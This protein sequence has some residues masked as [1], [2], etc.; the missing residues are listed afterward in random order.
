MSRRDL[1]VFSLEAWDDVWRRNQYLIDG[2]LRRD[3]DLRVLFVEP[4]NDLLHSALSGRGIRRGRGLRTTSGYD[5]RLSLFQPDKV[6]PRVAGPAADAALRRAARR[7]M[8]SLGVTRPVLWVN[9]PGWAAL[10]AR[11][12]LPSVYDMTDDWLA[13]DRPARERHRIVANE[14]I[15]M[16]RCAAVVVCSTGLERSRSPERDVI[17]IPNAVDTAR[18]RAPLP[19]PADLPA[20]P[21]AVYVGT[22]HEDR[23][24]VDLVVR[25]AETIAAD[26]G[27]IVLVGP[28]ALATRNTELLTSHPDVAVL[29][30]RPF[31]D[32]PAYLQHA[33]S[34]IVPHVVDAFTDSLDPIKLYEYRAVGRPIV[35]TPVAG[36]R[37][38]E[39]EGIL[40]AARADFPLAV[41]AALRENAPTLTVADVPD[42][43]DRVDDYARVLEPLFA[44]AAAS[45]S[46]SSRPR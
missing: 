40:L 3:P 23:L 4:S 28:D 31:R 20:G 37:D 19:R 42:W 7:A 5:G 41:A 21:T 1:V 22:L 33:T 13:A 36:F 44:D 8:R 17:L 18:Y 35:S 14:A 34:L 45:A 32:I 10:V 38:L 30:P 16:Q 11:T 46:D 2:L 15:L 9:D 43:S 25:T 27:S 12:G 24:D 39:G 26:G 6:L 29:G